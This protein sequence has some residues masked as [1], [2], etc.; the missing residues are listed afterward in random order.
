MVF[1]KVK[2]E[3]LNSP[4]PAIPLLVTHPEKMKARSQGEIL[5][6]MLIAALFT[7]CGNNLG[8]LSTHAWLR[9]YDTY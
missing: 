6:P 9:R 1:P 8:Y 3:E 4:Q 5:T 2:T 7:I